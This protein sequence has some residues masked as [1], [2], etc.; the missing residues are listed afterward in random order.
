M[1][2]LSQIWVN[3]EVLNKFRNIFLLS[4]VDLGLPQNLNLKNDFN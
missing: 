4:E 2:Q 3:T 1:K